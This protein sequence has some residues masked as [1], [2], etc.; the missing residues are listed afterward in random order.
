M[1]SQHK[2]RVL[3]AEDDGLVAEMI[4]GILAEEDYEVEGIVGDGRAVLEAVPRLQPDV[5]VMDLRMPQMDG[6]E[7][8]RRIQQVCPTPVV[9]LTAYDSMQLTS[10]AAAAGV[11]AYLVKPPNGRD[12]ARAITVARA[13]FEEAQSLDAFAH[14]VAHDLKSAMTP[15]LCVAE[16][17]SEDLE[18]TSVE[19][20][21]LQLDMIAETGYK[22]GRMVD[23]LLML[24]E[25]RY[26]DVTPCPL[27]MA[28]I[29]EEAQ[30]RLASVA[31]R[32]GAH[33][34]VPSRWPTAL[35]LTSWVTEVWVNYLSNALK[36]GGRPPVVSL[37]WD[38]FPSSQARLRFWV[39][40]NGSGLTP[41]EQA[42]LFARYTRL[43]PTEADGHGLG[44]SIVQ[45]IVRKLGGSVGV[46]SEGDRG[47][48]FWFTLPTPP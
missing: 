26:R 14:T 7:T 30:S 9:M 12:L 16:L 1:S 41:E 10:E 42:H 31:D 43:R 4:R 28:T 39:R 6:I 3:I 5:V 44:L 33:V 17:L 24:A 8:T 27:D 37:G 48:T 21:R 23:D 34:D 36:Y 45:Q 18:V 40:D 25:I 15:I 35:G 22:L 13:R 19:N 32:L 2:G 11:G 47:C 46:E 29:V 38:E 20:A